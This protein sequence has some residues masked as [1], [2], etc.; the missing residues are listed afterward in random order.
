MKSY[1]LA[2]Y[3]SDNLLDV[4]VSEG[5]VKQLAHKREN[6]NVLSLEL[7]GIDYKCDIDSL[8]ECVKIIEDTLS[9]LKTMNVRSDDKFLNLDIDNVCNEI[10]VYGKR[11]R[12]NFLITDTKGNEI[13]LYVGCRIVDYPFR[14]L[15][16]H[17]KYAVVFSPEIKSLG[18][19]L[20]VV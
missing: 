17:D 14:V 13:I 4:E 6:V 11:G 16:H 15:R 12:G 3:V 7:V 1:N 19:N 5:Q 20:T 10:A 18:R 8:D 9:E 2:D